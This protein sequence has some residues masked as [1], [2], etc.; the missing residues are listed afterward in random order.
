[1][2][3]RL[4]ITS[5]V[6]MLVVAVALSTATYAWF[7]TS[8]NVSAEA[9]VLTA[10]T[11]NGDAILISK[12]AK[13]VDASNTIT[14]TA[15]EAG[16]ALYPATPLSADAFTVFYE[17]NATEEQIAANSIANIA[18][19]FKNL[20]M[21]GEGT[22]VDATS[23]M[24]AK[25]SSFYSETFY[26]FNKGFQSTTVIPTVNI[27]YD[28]LDKTSLMAAKSVRVAIVE[29]VGTQTAMNGPNDS[30]DSAAVA[31]TANGYSLKGIWQFGSYVKVASNATFNGEAP[32]YTV[33]GGVFS[34]ENVEDAD[35]FADKKANLYVVGTEAVTYTKVEGAVAFDAKAH[36]FT[37][38][39][40]ETFEA[41]NVTS[42][43][44]A[45]AKALETLYV[46]D[47]LT[48][49]AM[50]GANST[51]GVAG[52][53]S[54]YTQGSVT[55]VPSNFSAIGVA[56]SGNHIANEYTVVVWLEGWDDDC[57]NQITAGSFK[58]SLGFEASR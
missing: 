17:S 18:D 39:D 43:T 50:K 48:N 31:F 11:M 28:P 36:Y 45:A 35:D 1:M 3:K 52:T 26:I 4:L 34:T 55:F 6:M 24:G 13:G 5:I 30:A 58:I 2:K 21:K 27:S 57:T 40:G 23:E 54:S 32:Y 12:S 25:D 20:I 51:Y 22:Y 46:S 9:V 49:L 15:V 42:E 10:A 14:L 41:A 38:S 33:S 7:T 44:F 53:S 47:A 37:S 29:R 8:T 19:N 16:S 56:D